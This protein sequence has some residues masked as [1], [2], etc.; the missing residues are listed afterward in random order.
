MLER[1][2]LMGGIVTDVM[3]DRYHLVR[4]TI[5]VPNGHR[6]DI[7]CDNGELVCTRVI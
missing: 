6:Y 2:E 5:S 4:V 3:F 1:N 7:L